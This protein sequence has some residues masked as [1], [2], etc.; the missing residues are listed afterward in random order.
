[1]VPMKAIDLNIASEAELRTLPGITADYARRIIA[2]RPYH[3]IEEVQ[4]TGIPRAVLDRISPPATLVIRNPPVP[5]Q[6]A[7]Q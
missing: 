6:P 7:R 3:S 5:S 2:G 4:K 1:M